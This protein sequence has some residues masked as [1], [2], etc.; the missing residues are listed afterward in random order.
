MSTKSMTLI[1]FAVLISGN[2]LSRFFLFFLLWISI[3]DALLFKPRRM[4]VPT[5]AVHGPC[6]ECVCSTQGV[7][8]CWHKK[9]DNNETETTDLDKECEPSLTYIEKSMICSCSTTGDWRS[10]N[11]RNRFRRIQTKNT[12]TKQILRTNIGCTPFMLYL[13]DCNI[14]R[15]EST[16]VFKPSSCTNR[17]CASKNKA[18]TCTAGDIERFGNELCACSDVNYFIDKLCSPINEKEVQTVEDRKLE[19]FVYADQPWRR[20]F[21]DNHRCKQ[22][23]TF[24]IDC[25]TCVCKKNRLECTNHVCKAKEIGRSKN[26]VKALP[27][28]KSPDEKCKPGRKYKY[29]CNICVCAD[30]GSPTCTNMICL[31]DFILD[32]RAFRGAL[33]TSGKPNLTNIT[34]IAEIKEQKC[35]PGQNYKIDCNTC[36][37]KNDGNLMCTKVLCLTNKRPIE[38]RRKNTENI[39]MAWKNNTANKKGEKEAKPAKKK[40]KLMEI[41]T[42]PDTCVPGKIYKKGCQKCF[43]QDNKKGVCTKKKNACKEKG[44]RIRY[45]KD[46]RPPFKSGEVVNFPELQHRQVRCE[47]GMS[48]R[49]DCNGCVCLASHD[50]ICD[51]YICLSYDDMHRIDA[52]EKSSKYFN[53][54]K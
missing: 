39:A 1:Q 19:K 42:L 43:C 40:N 41:P 14:C 12:L 24:T 54:G 4:C 49:V 26:S 15:C 5:A 28:L 11:C 3:A 52:D 35:V 13:I 21:E 7:Y 46:I 8:H 32:L 34:R 45:L 33:K 30:D 20:S 53:I 37:C 47:P 36:F 22:N 18:A 27:E 48:Y 38:G 6:H 16:G 2:M 9:C 51:E 23:M 17:P 31:E 50:L 44:F 10:S 25:N 29:K